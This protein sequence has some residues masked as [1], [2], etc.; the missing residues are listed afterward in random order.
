M[1]PRRTLEPHTPPLLPRKGVIVHEDWSHILNRFRRP[2]AARFRASLVRVG[3]GLLLDLVRRGPVP[4]W[5]GAYASPPGQ[6]LYALACDHL[7]WDP[8]CSAGAGRHNLPGL[9]QRHAMARGAAGGI[10]ALPT[11]CR[12]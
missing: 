11:G 3:R 7:Q 9:A 10:S 6:L 4:R 5:L 12:P 8:G 1:S 2:A